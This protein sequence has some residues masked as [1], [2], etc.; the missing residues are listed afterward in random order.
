MLVIS[1]YFG[2]ILCFPVAGYDFELRKSS[3]DVAFVEGTANLASYSEG[4]I[5]D[6]GVNYDL[7]VEGCGLVG[8]FVADADTCDGV[9][10]C[11]VR[12]PR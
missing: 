11:M 1:G 2:S 3:S 4:F 6:S 12:R 8:S 10:T 7:Y 5:L 9:T